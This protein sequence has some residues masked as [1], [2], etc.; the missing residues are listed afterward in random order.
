MVSR[1]F[2]LF[3]REINGLHEAAFLLAFSAIASQLLGLVRDRLLAGTFGA[4]ATLDVYYSAF[5]VPDLIYVSI[6]SFVSVT[7]LI[8]FIMEGLTAGRKSET[9][10]FINQLFSVF[11]A[12]MAVVSLAAFLLMP[13]LAQVVAPGFDA[14]QTDL[15]IT[16]SRI[17]LLSP[18]FL[19]LSNLF[20]GVTQGL[21][22]FFVYAA[23][24]IFYNLGIIAGVVVFYPL[25]GA[26][27]LAYGVAL[28]ALLH[29][30]VQLPII[31]QTG[32]WPRLVWPTDW[33]PIKEV[34]LTSFPRTI[35]LSAHQ[36]ALLALVALAS[37]F[38]VGAISVFNLAW[39]LQS[40][41]LSIVGVSYSV[42]AFPA[43]ARLF[44][45]GERATFL[46]QI[47]TATRHI[48]FWSMIAT[49][50]FIVLRAQVVR[51]ILGS[52]QFGW[53]ETRLVAA[54]LAIFA[55]SVAAQSLVLLLVRGYYAAGRTIVPLVV[56]T[57]SSLF[58]IGL[59]FLYSF[60]FVNWSF[61]RWF[62]EALLRVGDV[63][64]TEVLLLPLAFST[65]LLINLAA[66]W[67]FF[68][69]DFG[70][71]GAAVRASLWQSFAA[72]TFGGFV[73]YQ[74]LSILATRLD[75]DTFRGIFSQGLG[76]GLAGLSATFILLWALD[77]REI[78][79]L[80]STLHRKFW[81][82]T[83]IAPGPEEL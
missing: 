47:K 24:P 7:V 58:I 70:S 38:S 22:R 53:T 27:G 4:G 35:T 13:L 20:G 71:L 16:L 34:I 64:G 52:G 9:H 26:V 1:L 69:R 17:I 30:A 42:A 21:R 11:L 68:H 60:F 5:R 57:L 3:S 74:V 62:L 65:G 50:F 61:G 14:A 23:S 43:L 76:A 32:F 29:L 83:V 78:S 31:Y 25:V 12:V 82:S 10:R 6:A 51:V 40:V 56:N 77:N 81:R 80:W 66:L 28:G 19:G 37:T 45:Q 59:A 48:V 39:N 33:Q 55:V 54:A 36:L 15:L 49:V 18:V 73:A 2:S 67:H 8:P 44:A 72:A 46:K 63:P 41:P 79:E 75:L